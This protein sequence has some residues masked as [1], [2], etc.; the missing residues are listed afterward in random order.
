[1]ALF[2][3]DEWNQPSGS[4]SAYS[5]YLPLARF[6]TSMSW[7]GSVHAYVSPSIDRPIVTSRLLA[8]PEPALV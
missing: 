7:S 8:P 6:V 5:R 2:F 4:A 1:V 3:V